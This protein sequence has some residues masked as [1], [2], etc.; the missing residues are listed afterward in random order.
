MTCWSRTEG[1]ALLSDAPRKGVCD[2]CLA[3]LGCGLVVVG[4]RNDNGS[5]Y[6]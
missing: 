3:N 1:P 5:I 2:V 4:L 6:I